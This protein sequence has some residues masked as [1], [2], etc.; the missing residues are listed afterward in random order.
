MKITSVKAAVFCSDATDLPKSLEE[1][2]AMPVKHTTVFPK[3]L[4][5]LSVM[6]VMENDAGAGVD[7]IEAIGMEASGMRVNV[8]HFEDGFAAFGQ[9]GYKTVCGPAIA[10]SAMMDDWE[11]GI[12][13]FDRANPPPVVSISTFRH[14]FFRQ[15][16]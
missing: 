7:V 11:W 4:A 10:E 3:E 16:F 13:P 8:D 12:V 5:P 14:I 15:D 6:Y 1:K 9:L 2:L